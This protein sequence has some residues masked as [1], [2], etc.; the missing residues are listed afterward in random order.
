M[1]EDE[2]KHSFPCGPAYQDQEGTKVLIL[3]RP[4]DTKFGKFIGVTDGEI[5]ALYDADELE[6]YQPVRDWDISTTAVKLTE[7]L[8]TN[9]VETTVIKKVLKELAGD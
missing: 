2:I 3:S 6:P 8:V 9:S 5:L 4:E 7:I 1:R